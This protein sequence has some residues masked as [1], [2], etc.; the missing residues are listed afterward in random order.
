MEVG[1]GVYASFSGAP[2]G[3][4]QLSLAQLQRGGGGERQILREEATSGGAH[5]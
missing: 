3:K 4:G 2:E 1:E 5:S